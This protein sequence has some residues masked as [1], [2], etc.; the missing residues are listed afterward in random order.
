MRHKR[1]RCEETTFGPGPRAGGGGAYQRAARSQEEQK[2][3]QRHQQGRSNERIRDGSLWPSVISL[4]CFGPLC[5]TIHMITI[6]VLS[7]QSVAVFP[8]PRC[9]AMQGKVLLSSRPS[10]KLPECLS[11]S[12]S[13]TTGASG[14]RSS[15]V[16]GSRKTTSPLS[17]NIP[18]GLN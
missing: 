4:V 12:P 1:R 5:E 8:R 6:A 7:R 2:A 9:N 14:S 17:K 16:A 13:S 15:A 3:S 11:L 18:K 10:W